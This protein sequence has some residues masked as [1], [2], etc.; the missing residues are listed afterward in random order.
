MEING[1]LSKIIECW[2]I[3]SFAH[4]DGD[5]ALFYLFRVNSG[6]SQL[7]LACYGLFRVVLLLQATTS[8]NVLIWKF[9]I[10]QLHFRFYWKV[11]EALLQL[12]AA[13][14][15]YKVWQVLLQ[16]ATTFLYYKVGNMVL[17]YRARI[18]KWGNLY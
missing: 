16:S 4:K 9:T 2:A 6:S 3:L 1:I 10:N 15:Y 14:M 7:V 13:W 17:Q 18:A 8:Q 5:F 11:G 12:E